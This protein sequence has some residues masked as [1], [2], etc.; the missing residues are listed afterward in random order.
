MLYQ[1]TTVPEDLPWHCEK[2]A[3]VLIEA[4]SQRPSGGKALDLGRG[5]GVFSVFLAKQGFDV[6]GL[7]FIP[8]ALEKVGDAARGRDSNVRPLCGGW[9]HVG[10]TGIFR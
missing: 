5:A 1:R 2:P 3:I 10:K 6:T 7:Y 9:F 8:K 4:A